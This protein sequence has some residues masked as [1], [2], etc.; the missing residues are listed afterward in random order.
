MCR[1]RVAPVA[2][3]HLTAE[4]RLGSKRLTHSR[5]VDVENVEAAPGMPPR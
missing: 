1:F 2:E 3:R 5:G 4:V